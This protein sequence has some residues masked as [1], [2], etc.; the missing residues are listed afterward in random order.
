AP[1]P[2]WASSTSSRSS[3]RRSRARRS[4]RGVSEPGGGIALR[5]PGV[6]VALE[7]AGELLRLLLVQPAADVPRLGL[8]LRP[9]PLDEG[10]E[11]VGRGAVRKAV[12]LRVQLLG[13]DGEVV[14]V[15]QKGAQRVGLFRQ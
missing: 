11:P 10:R 2:T 3:M 7:A 6:P 4:R 14:V 9:A 1:T 15:A 5:A 13:Q 8:Q 12:G